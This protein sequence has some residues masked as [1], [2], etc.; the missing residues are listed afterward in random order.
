MKPTGYLAA[1]GAALTLAMAATPSAAKVLKAPVADWTGGA[2]TCEILHQIV[3]SELGYKV[4]RITM[5]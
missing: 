5:P 4:K 2:V 3:E 1:A